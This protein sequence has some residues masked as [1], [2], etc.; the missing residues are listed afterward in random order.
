MVPLFPGVPGG[1]ELLVILLVAIVAFGL[2]L[3]LIAAGVIGY[4]RLSD[5][6]RIEK[7]EARIAELEERQD[8]NE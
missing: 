4:K 2:P 7:L 3:V 6:D 5:E 8:D 1:L